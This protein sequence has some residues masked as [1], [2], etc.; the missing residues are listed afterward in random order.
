LIKLAR[1]SV[2][3]ERECAFLFL[4]FCAR[5]ENGTVVCEWMRGNSAEFSRLLQTGYLHPQ[6]WIWENYYI[7]FVGNKEF[8]P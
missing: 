4:P 6:A 8:M 2:C 1:E 3:A 5:K 7:I